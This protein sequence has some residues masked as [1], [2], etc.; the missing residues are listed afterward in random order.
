[1]ALKKKK[2]KLKLINR[3][4]SDRYAEDGRFKG[5]SYCNMRNL[6]FSA[7]PYTEE[8]KGLRNGGGYKMRIGY[9]VGE[10]DA[11]RSVFINRLM[12]KYLP[13]LQTNVSD[14][15]WRWNDN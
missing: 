9:E 2:T 13:K 14:N 6:P 7:Y 3:F 5:G 12:Q 8:N 4:L 11:A 1:M 15:E 10:P